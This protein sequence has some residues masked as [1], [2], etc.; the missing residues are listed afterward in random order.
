[1]AT[2][3]R[4]GQE[5]AANAPQEAATNIAAAMLHAKYR[6]EP[7]LMREEAMNEIECVLGSSLD[8]LEDYADNTNPP[9]ALYAS[10]YLLKHVQALVAHVSAM[11][12][13][14]GAAK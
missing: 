1:M 13:Q 5:T 8:A 14:T 12:M 4:S 7:G 9:Q 11:D 10:I 3:D 2:S 6:F